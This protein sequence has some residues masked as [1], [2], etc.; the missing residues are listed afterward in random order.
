MTSDATGDDEG[1]LNEIIMLSSGSRLGYSKNPR[2]LNT[3]RC[4]FYVPAKDGVQQA[5]A[6]VMDFGDGETTGILP[7]DH[8]PLTIEHTADAW[9]TI[10]GMKLDN[11]PTKKGVY[12]VNGKKVKR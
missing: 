12:I 11:V 7:I 3:F 9:Y 8:S 1:N 5:R 4:H 6:F 2:T 10:D